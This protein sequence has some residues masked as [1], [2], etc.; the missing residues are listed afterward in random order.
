VQS[1]LENGD[2]F[3]L[4]A[5]IA[6]LGTGIALLAGH[7]GERPLGI[8]VITLGGF[9]L[10]HFA[11]ERYFWSVRAEFDPPADTGMRDLASTFVA[12]SGV[13]LGLL[14]LFGDKTSTKQSDAFTLTLKVGST[15]LAAA[16]LI[17]LV[18][19]GLLLMGAKPD[20]QRA[21]NVV[22]V[23]FN[24]EL[25]AFSLGLLCIAIALVYQ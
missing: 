4:G 16:I 17:G 5:G 21:W 11:V 9:I 23:V 24:V 22:R 25:W 18:L 1:K 10:C 19:I 14:T 13:V 15:S 8:A 2:L 12:T 6:S 7:Y 3:R 20:D